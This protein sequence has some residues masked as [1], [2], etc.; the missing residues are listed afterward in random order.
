MGQKTDKDDNTQFLTISPPEGATSQ[1]PSRHRNN[2]K[3]AEGGF[4]GHDEDVVGHGPP[5]S[6]ISRDL[7]SAIRITISQS[8]SN[9][10]HHL[11]GAKIEL[12]L[13]R[14]SRD[15]PARYLPPQKFDFPGF[16]RTCRT[17]WAPPLHV[18][19]PHPTRKHPDSK[20]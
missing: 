12:K 11:V 17:F 8:Q 3:N 16:Q 19:D 2:K 20:V 13:F 18:E 14:M 6:H 9:K 7:R 1:T 15:I 5:P 4:Q 10:S